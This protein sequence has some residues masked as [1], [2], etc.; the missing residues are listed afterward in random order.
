[1]KFRKWLRFGFRLGLLLVVL[2]IATV[3]FFAELQNTLPPD[4]RAAPEKAT[5]YSLDP[6]GHYRAHPGDVRFHGFK[7]LGYADLNV[8]QTAEA[9]RAFRWAI[10]EWYG[11]AECFDAR[12]GLRVT[13]NGHTYDFLLCYECGRLEVYRDN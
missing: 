3:V 8:L 2:G 10:F 7:I 6:A 11:S 4:A 5:L 9:C 1:M 13:S 12:H